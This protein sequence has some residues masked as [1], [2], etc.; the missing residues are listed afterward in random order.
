MMIALALGYRG[1]C[2]HGSQVQSD[3]STVQGCLQDALRNL[4]W[5]SELLQLSSRTDAGV[6]ARMNLA[7]CWVPDSI[8]LSDGKHRIL[9]AI[10]DLLPAMIRIWDAVE[11]SADVEIRHANHRTYRYRLEA[12]DDWEQMIEFNQVEEALRLFEGRHDFVNFCRAEE[13]RPSTRTIDSCVPW[14]AEDG[15]LIGFEVKASGFLWHQIRRMASAIRSV[16]SGIIQ[17]EDVRDALE[18]PNIEVDFG[19]APAEWLVL[20]EISHPLVNLEANG[21]MLD[22][23]PAQRFASERMIVNAERE[24]DTL[25]HRA[26]INQELAALMIA[27]HR[28]SQSR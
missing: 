11:L 10:N 8:T 15:R 1:D 4:D 20:W 28:H 9:R 12:L 3:V 22:P 24:A 17:I 2:F 7:T 14:I 13:N 27:N 23:P 6:H 18:N 25:R 16:V 5:K 26:W 21:G 19:M